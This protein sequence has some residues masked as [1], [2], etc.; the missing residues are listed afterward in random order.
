MA[1]AAAVAASTRSHLCC[2]AGLLQAARALI[3]KDRHDFPAYA[4]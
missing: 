4:R 3:I 2:A 1:A